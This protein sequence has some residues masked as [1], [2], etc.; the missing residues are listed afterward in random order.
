M[1]MRKETGAE[2]TGLPPISL[3]LRAAAADQ[4][5]PVYLRLTPESWQRPLDPFSRTIQFDLVGCGVCPGLAD[6][7]CS[8]LASLLGC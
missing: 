5:Q 6:G 8:D 1:A 4:S 7:G 3:P 2:G